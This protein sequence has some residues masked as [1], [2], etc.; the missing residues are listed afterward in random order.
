M[1]EDRPLVQLVKNSRYF[2]N[3]SKP[4]E[5]AVNERLGIGGLGESRFKL[6]FFLA[7]YRI[8]RNAI[9]GAEIDDEESSTACTFTLHRAFGG[10][11]FF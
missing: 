1:T 10:A 11:G 3:H 8:R 7:L 2:P 4:M 5:Y 6:L 9:D